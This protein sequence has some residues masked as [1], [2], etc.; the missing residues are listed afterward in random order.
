MKLKSFLLFGVVCAAVTLTSCDKS[1][2]NIDTIY[3]QSFMNC[4]AVVT[5]M[6]NP[7]NQTVST[8]ITM[9][10]TT[11]WTKFT[12]EGTIAGLKLDG[13][14]YPT[15]TVS[16][17]PWTATTW[18]TASAAS[19]QATLTTGTPA[20]ISEFKLEWLDRLDFGMAIGAYDPGM[21]FS[22]VL[23]GRYKVVGSRAPIVLAGTTTSVP[24]EGPE[25]STGKAVYSFMLDFEK[26]TAEIRLVNIQFSSMMP[27]MSQ[28]SFPGVP[29]TIAE[30]G[31]TINLQCESLIPSIG[32]TPYPTFPIT[33]LSG[34]ITP[35]TGAKLEFV[36]TYKDVP[37]TVTA[38][39]NYTSYQDAIAGN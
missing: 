31:K 7:T 23:D 18:C 6:M 11:N 15:I 10:W 28:M 38:D 13:S 22:F 9:K 1:N 25:F 16:N 4:Y 37:F 14:T 12:A 32:T 35:G 17:I 8:P 2:D 5:D 24:A 3:E 34:T 19:P 26:R 33:Q 27:Q 39:I 20:L 36:C 30:D 29:F 21:T